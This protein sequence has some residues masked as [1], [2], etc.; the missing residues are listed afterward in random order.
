MSQSALILHWALR[1]ISKQCPVWIQQV[2]YL[3]DDMTRIRVMQKVS[4]NNR[5][6]H[7]STSPP[8]LPLIH[9]KKNSTS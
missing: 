9:T 8:Q 7:K 4:H 6:S 5:F 2:I 1:R 3:S